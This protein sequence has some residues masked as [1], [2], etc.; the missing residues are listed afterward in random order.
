VDAWPDEGD[1]P[2]RNLYL[3]Y[4]GAHDNEM[5]RFTVTRHG[6]NPAAVQTVTSTTAFMGVRGGVNVGLGDGHAEFSRLPDLWSYYWHKDWNPQLV[7]IGPP[8]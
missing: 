4:Y 3:G 2:S 7:T 6:V 5:G 1:G 8:Q